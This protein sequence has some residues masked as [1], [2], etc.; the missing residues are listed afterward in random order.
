MRKKLTLNNIVAWVASIFLIVA[1]CLTFASKYTLIGGGA[2]VKMPKIVWGVKTISGYANGQYE[3]LILPDGYRVGPAI[4]PL[5]GACLLALSAVLTIIISLAVDDITKRKTAVGIVAIVAVIGG[6]LSFFVF[7]TGRKQMVLISDGA[8][9]LE[10][11]E[12]AIEAG[13]ISESAGGAIATGVVAI[14]GGLISLI[15]Q[16]VPNKQL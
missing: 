5:I 8:M 14:I 7:K 10:Q 9:T 6:V 16:I 13:A 3:I 4:V 11:L 1:F 15:S 2:V 12:A